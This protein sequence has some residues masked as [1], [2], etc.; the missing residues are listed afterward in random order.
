MLAPFHL[1]LW[2]LSRTPWG[3]GE[4]RGEVV[5][6]ASNK[7]GEEMAMPKIA[8]K[9]LIPIQSCLSL[10][11]D[12]ELRSHSYIFAAHELVPRMRAT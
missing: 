7:T 5:T 9:T 3:C 4:V 12:S 8:M 2:L 11:M 1:L 6:G 10:T